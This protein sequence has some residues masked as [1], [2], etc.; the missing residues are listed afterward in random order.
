[1][2]RYM[3]GF[4]SHWVYFWKLTALMKQINDALFPVLE[5]R[6]N[7]VKERVILLRNRGKTPLPLIKKHL[8]G[9]GNISHLMMEMG[10]CR[11]NNRDCCLRRSDGTFVTCYTTIC[12]IKTEIITSFLVTDLQSNQSS[13]EYMYQY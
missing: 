9:L 3:H 2:Y 11:S 13:T 4:F 6:L 5:K 7:P 12:N 8:A 1:M 10:C